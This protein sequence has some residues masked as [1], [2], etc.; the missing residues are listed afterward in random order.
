MFIKN[1]INQVNRQITDLEKLFA[2]HISYIVLITRIYKE[3]QI[4]KKKTIHLKMGQRP[5]QAL[6]KRGYPDGQ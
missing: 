2:V 6:H 3:L 4:C 1:T 5:E